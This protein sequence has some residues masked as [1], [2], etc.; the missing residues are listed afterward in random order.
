MGKETDHIHYDFTNDYKKLPIKSRARLIK[1]AKNL[2]EQQMEDSVF[3][4]ALTGISSTCEDKRK[5]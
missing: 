2:L 4:A 1:G 3:L 5:R